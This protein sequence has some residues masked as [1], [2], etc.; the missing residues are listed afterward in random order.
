MGFKI[1][2]LSTMSSIATNLDTIASDATTKLNSTSTA[3]DELVSN[4]KGQNIDLTLNNLKNG[5]NT[6]GGNTVTLLNDISAFITSQVG[7]YTTNEETVSQGLN[8]ISNALDGME[9]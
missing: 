2:S 9:V 4:V 6:T 7:S 5:I 3:L 1:E 8:D